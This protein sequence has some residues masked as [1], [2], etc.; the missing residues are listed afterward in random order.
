MRFA[1]LVLL[2]A[3]V[4]A[5]AD[6]S[7]AGPRGNGDPLSDVAR[8]VCEADGSTFVLTPRVLAQRDGVH[9]IVDNQLDEPASLIGGFGFDVDLGVSEWTLQAGPGDRAVACW[10]FSEH[11]GG[12]EPGTVPLQVLDPEGLYVPPAELECPDNKQW[13]S[14]LDF[15]DMSAGIAANPVDAVR[16]SINGLDSGHVVS[17]SRSGYPEAD[18]EGGSTVVVSRDGRAVAI[19]ELTLADD[20]RWLINGGR[21]C[22]NVGIDFG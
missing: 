10:P 6:A 16:R 18:N 21:G 1:V 9:V 13:S 8:I 3:L 20:G 5:C 19:F 14:V 7:P 17:E 15:L 22:A 12:D 2:T 4:A 11:G